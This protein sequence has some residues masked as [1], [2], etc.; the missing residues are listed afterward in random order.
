MAFKHV[1]VGTDFKECS[2]AAVDHAVEI[3]STSGAALTLVHVY[4][5]PVTFAEVA[6]GETLPALEEAAEARLEQALEPVRAR[7]PR[8]KGVVRCGAAWE[9]LLEVAREKG[10]DLIV[11]GSHGR[12]GL[13]RALI[14]SVAEKVVRLASVP[15]LTVHGPSP[16]DALWAGAPGHP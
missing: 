15:V 11:V 5:L 7:L 16:S 9:Q 2:R 8:A 10:A 3:A 6:V 13:P 1:L 4:D 14:G 12:K